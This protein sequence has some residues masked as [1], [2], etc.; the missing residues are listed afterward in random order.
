VIDLLAS[1]L[2]TR[3]VAQRLSLSTTGVRVH[4][5]AAVKKLGVRDRAEAIALFRRARGS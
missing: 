4:A 5:A 2:S 3:D 1:G